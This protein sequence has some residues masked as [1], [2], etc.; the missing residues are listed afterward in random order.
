[1]YVRADTGGSEG[2]MGVACDNKFGGKS[3]V[4][5]QN[6]SNVVLINEVELA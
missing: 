4:R 3:K 5:R 6:K 1:M 2:V